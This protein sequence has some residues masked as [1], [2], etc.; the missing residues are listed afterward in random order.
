MAEWMY[1][2][3]APREHFAA[4][5]T[6]R[7]TGGVGPALRAS[8]AA[9]APKAPSSSPVRRWDGSTPVS[10]CSKLPT[11]PPL[12]QLIEDDPAIA[13]GIAT[14]ELRPSRRPPSRPRLR[15]RNLG[16]MLQG[17]SVCVAV[18]PL[19]DDGGAAI[20]ALARPRP[21]ATAPT[22]AT[23][24]ST[25]SVGQG[26]FQRHDSVLNFLRT[27]GRHGRTDLDGAGA[28]RPHRL[29][30]RGVRVRRAGR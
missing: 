8:A 12:G 20:V 28:P 7:R 15:S 5:M 1:F 27:G 10:A 2:I 30:P 17:S 26:L 13:S 11:R 19:F 18:D 6:H 21:S 22:A 16:P 24:R 14:G 4:T 9:A 23:R 25:P 3:H 29:P